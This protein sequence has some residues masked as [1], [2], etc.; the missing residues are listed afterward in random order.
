MNEFAG[1]MA[2][3]TTPFDDKTGDVDAVALRNNARGL[4]DAGLSGLLAVGSTGEAAL[5]DEHEYRQ[6]IEW[7]RDVVPDEKRLMVG[8]G[9]ES[10]RGTVVACKLAGDVGADAVLVRAPTYYGGGLSDGALIDHFRVIADE[11]PVPVFLYNIPK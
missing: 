1:V 11:S 4:L 6:V 10:T 2:P 7:L 9:R 5:L 8:A 3:I